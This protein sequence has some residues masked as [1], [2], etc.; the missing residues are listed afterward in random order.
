MLLFFYIKK[1]EIIMSLFTS[2]SHD[3]SMDVLPEHFGKY[4]SN[5]FDACVSEFLELWNKGSMKADAAYQYIKWMNKLDKPTEL[6]TPYANLEESFSRYAKCDKAVTTGSAYYTII[7]AIASFVICSIGFIIC[8]LIKSII[9]GV[10]FALTGVALTTFFLVQIA[11]SR[12][13]LNK[14]SNLSAK[15]KESLAAFADAF[16]SIFGTEPIQDPDEIK[17]SAIIQDEA[18]KN[19]VMYTYKNLGRVPSY[20]FKTCVQDLIDIGKIDDN[21]LSAVTAL[22]EWMATLEVPSELHTDMRHMLCSL[23]KLKACTQVAKVTFFQVLVI[24][25][26]VFFLLG[27]PFWI[28]NHPI[29]DY[30]PHFLGI[31]IDFIFTPC[32]I[33]DI[34]RAKAKKPNLMTK[35]QSDITSF[36]DNFKSLNI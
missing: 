32:S 35:A 18:H 24:L 1:G 33:I 23:R 3:D 15:A 25:A 17:Y 2:L 27:L 7:G 9:V 16:Y 28:L 34:I 10:A 13:E 31:I 29:S 21:N 12:F 26:N 14:I 30:W 22:A 6:C 5:R 36:V 8:M 20:D 11:H 4:P 19:V